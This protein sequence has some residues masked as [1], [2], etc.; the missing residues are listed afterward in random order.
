M[1][2][3]TLIGAACLLLGTTDTEGFTPLFNG[4]DLSGWVNVNGAEDTWRAEEGMI[5]ST[6]KPIC[7]LRTDQPYENFILELEWRHQEANG[8][9]G[10]FVWSDALPAVGTPFARAIELQ[11]MLGLET[12][13]YT[14]EGD[15]FSIWGAVMT[16][17]RPHPQGW[18]RCLP[19]ENRT[20]G[21][22]EWNHYRVTCL[23]GRVSLEVNGKNVSGGFD[24]NP[25]R[26]Y[27]CLEAEG[28]PIDFR[29]LRIKELPTEAGPWADSANMATGFKP[30]YN[31]LDL[32]GWKPPVDQ[33]ANWSSRGGILF[34]NG[35]GGHLWTNDSYGDFD[36][37]VDWRWTKDHQGEMD[38]PI[39]LP[40]GSIAT[41]EE[42]KQRTMKVEERD[43]GIFLRGS[44]KSQVNLWCWPIGSGEVYGY[45]TDGSMPA[46]VRA[47]V[48]PRV[49]ADEPVG[50]WNRYFI[51]MRGDRLTVVL[52]GQTVIDR[53]ELPG[54]PETGPIGLQSHGNEVEFRNV[55]IRRR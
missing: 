50:K 47:A 27:I 21:A 36:L 1:I 18:Q 17:D 53:A 22:G 28:S 44:S 4:E 8:N 38:R 9:A 52:N 40:D 12:P 13:N 46:E 15:V 20:K 2:M 29:N 24:C 39:I 31:G 41:D 7:L 33:E 45:R 54:V 55:L 3:T 30:I 10:L 11:V 43:S 49:N 5:R 26:G 19:S 25:R 48:T 16:P 14:S 32:T 6:G 34:H 35:N 42:G 23:D 51:R 37:V